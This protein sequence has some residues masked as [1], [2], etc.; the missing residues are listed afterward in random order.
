VTE[1]WRSP[2]ARELVA[3]I[4]AAGGTVERVGTGRLRITGPTGAC[5]I[6]EPSTESRRD[7]RANS[8]ERTITAQT[9]L[10]LS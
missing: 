6:H 2:A 5:T 10:T 7:L 8:A 1:R 4:R 3:R 9:G